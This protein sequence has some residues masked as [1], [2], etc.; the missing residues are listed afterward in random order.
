MASFYFDRELEHE[1]GAVLLSGIPES[2][3]RNESGEPYAL[4]RSAHP[5]ATNEV[6]ERPF[7]DTAINIFGI[8]CLGDRQSDRWNRYPGFGR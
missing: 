6:F 4:N 3:H 8:R 1:H 2:V 5:R 7:G